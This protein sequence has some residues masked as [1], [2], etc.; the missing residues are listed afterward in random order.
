MN[1]TL[2]LLLA[3][4]ATTFWMGCSPRYY[5][6]AAYEEFAD[7]HQ[8]IAVLPSQMVTTGRIPPEWTEEQIVQIEENESH[9]FQ[10]AVFDEIAQRSG[11]R[12]GEILIYLQHYTETNAKLAEAGI[13]A[14]DS[15]TM[16]P[17]DL[18]SILGVDA[19]IRTGMRKDMWLTDLE[20][21][22]ISMAQTA[23]S[24][25][26]GTSP[27]PVITKTSDVF[28]SAS[29]LDGETGITVWNTDRRAATDWNTR[30]AQIVRHLARVLARRFPYRV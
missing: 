29:V 13:S 19:V 9:A 8:T 17:S 23:I 24:L 22:G 28:L 2:L 11:R 25:F 5:E 12:G 30:H 21:F 20:S 27:F 15:W 16:T 1:K 3:F 10:I 14:R 26:G 18:A 4:V 6:T 7:D